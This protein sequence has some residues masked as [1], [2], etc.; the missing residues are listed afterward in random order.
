MAGIGPAPAEKR[1]H[2]GQLARGDWVTLESSAPT[3]LPPLPD[4]T[5]W[6]DRAVDAWGRWCDD[7]ATSVYTSADVA[8]AL[9]TIRLYNEGMSASMAKEV[10]MRMTDLGLTP[11]GKRKLRYRVSQDADDV[12]GNKPVARQRRSHGRRSR[13]SV[14]K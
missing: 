14:V 6:S 11:E 4:D 9:D 10:R 7:P 12:S 3:A 8:F 13:L 1:R 5:E 2:N